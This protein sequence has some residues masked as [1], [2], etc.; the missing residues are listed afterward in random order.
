MTV[1]NPDNP[2]EE[3]L[4][5]I[6]VVSRV[7]E[8]PV[9]TLR[10][11]ER[12]YDF[13]ES[14]R[15]PGGHRL[16][17]EKEI[18]RLQ[19]VK[20]RIDEGMQTGRAIRALQHLEDED[21]QHF[22]PEPPLTA[23]TR[24]THQAAS[25]TPPPIPAPLPD[26]GSLGAFQQRLT[27]AFLNHDL[28]T[29]NQIF[30]EALAL[31]PLENLLLD[32]IRPTLVEIG[33]LWHDGKINVATEH[34]ASNYIRHRLLMW[35]VTGPPARNTPPIVMACAPGEWHEIT[36]LMFGV[37]LRRQG[38]PVTYL[39]QSL[40]LPDLAA[41]VQDVD[42]AAIIVVAMS[43]ETA[44]NLV[45]WPRWLPQVEQN[46]QPAF[47]YGGAAF[48]NDAAWQKKVP[49]LYLGDSLHEGLNRL[50]TLMQERYL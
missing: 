26:D 1:H 34:L 19:W 11:W 29:A 23:A 39:G 46:G 44:E 15:T 7:T 36:L 35:M 41:F 8:I 49:G 45:E 27:Q 40:P 2:S 4:Y 9:A 17:S 10:V 22:P 28:E 5:N 30:G 50:Q 18:M 42:P 20:A 31:Y 43:D 21:E 24:D 14:A 47:C 48:R 12:R 32:M 13:P 6:G 37:L 38:W 33:D 25:A 16:Y 3:P